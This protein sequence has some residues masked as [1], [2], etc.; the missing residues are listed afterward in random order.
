MSRDKRR[1]SNADTPKAASDR[2]EIKRPNLSLAEFVAT[3]S[4]L[5]DLGYIDVAGEPGRPGDAVLVPVP[6]HL[7]APRDVPPEVVQQE[8][9]ALIESDE[10]PDRLRRLL[11]RQAVAVLTFLKSNG[12]QIVCDTETAFDLVAAG[13]DFAITRYADRLRHLPELEEWEAKRIDGGEKGRRVLTTRALEQ[14]QRIR[15]KRA[16]L[17][18]AGKPC[19]YDVIA[20]EIGCSRSTVDRAINNRPTT[21]RKR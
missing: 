5:V 15:D 13:F 9:A 21:R 20:K 17:E 18:K 16:E 12:T 14:A 6:D 2:P 7:L 4:E 11:A 3:V 8:D 19:S 10:L 1:K